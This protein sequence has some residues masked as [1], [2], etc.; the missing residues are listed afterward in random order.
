MLF[1]LLVGC[2]PKLEPDST[3]ELARQYLVDQGYSLKSYEGSQVYSFEKHELV[4]MPHKSIWARQ[5][6]Q[7]DPYIGKEIIQ[8]IFIVKNH[9][10]S[11]IYGKKVEVRVFIVDGKIIG[12]TSYPDDDTMGGWGYSLEGKTAEEVQGDKLEEWSEEWN[13][14]YGQ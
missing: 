3:G 11:K 10:V 14:K 5:T 7:P 2:G 4:D 8:E 13:K 6:V 12:G 1:L 9:P